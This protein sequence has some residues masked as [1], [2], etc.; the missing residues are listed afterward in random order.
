MKISIVIPNYNGK[1]ILEKNLPKILDA[2][3]D[4]EIIVVDDAST[5]DS[6]KMLADKFPHIKVIKR[7]NNSGFATSVN[8][9]VKASSGDLVLLLNSDVVPENNFLKPLSKHFSDPQ[10]FAVGSLQYS[11]NWKGKD[12]HGRGIGEFKKGFFVHGPGA[13]N[14]TNTLWVF[15]GCGLYRKS[16]WEKFGG[17]ET[18]YNP[19]YWEDIDLSYRALKA[20][21]KLVF[22]PESVVYHQQEQGAIRSSYTQ[23]EIK[24][25]AYRNQIIFVWLNITDLSFLISHLFY[26][27]Y[28]LV[29]TIHKGDDAFF[30]GLIQA[31]V[32]LPQIIRKRLT[33]NRFKKISDQ[34]IL[35]ANKS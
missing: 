15:G 32:K 16:L 4:A 20:G 10:V 6:I 23:S 3:K 29:K 35:T 34:M 30:K 14:K 19:F 12:R 7:T 26:L 8:D 13:L 1:E 33:R 31:I 21:Y 17:M 25:I 24:T 28:T 9:G 18:L 27:P 2:A 22:E 5:D 11:S